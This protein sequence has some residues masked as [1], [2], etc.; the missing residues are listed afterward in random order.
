MTAPLDDETQIRML[1]QPM[2]DVISD[3]GTEICNLLR[4]R[5]INTDVM[6]QPS[7]RPFVAHAAGTELDIEYIGQ[8]GA[9]TLRERR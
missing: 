2:G 1:Q 8:N 9:P 3:S 7:S 6:Y 4:Q 5:G